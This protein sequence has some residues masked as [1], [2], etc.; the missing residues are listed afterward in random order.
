MASSDADQLAGVPEG[1]LAH[2]GRRYTRTEFQEYYPDTWAREWADAA[3]RDA[4]QLPV[5][6]GSRQNAKTTWG[7]WQE[8]EA[9]WDSA[10]SHRMQNDAANSWPVTY[11]RGAAS[12]HETQP[13]YESRVS[14]DPNIKTAAELWKKTVTR[15]PNTSGWHT[16]E[17][18]CRSQPKQREQ[19][20][21]AERQLERQPE[22]PQQP[23][24]P[25]QPERQRELPERQAEQLVET[26]PDAS[27]YL[28]QMD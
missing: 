25:E 1:R 16:V 15:K 3:D 19:S 26:Q 22:Q 11:D 20:E 23:E 28:D 13:A 10:N 18:Q 6:W 21:Q 17:L 8:E 2:D 27:T 5:T 9:A 12:S 4:A 14:T 7:S 24:Q